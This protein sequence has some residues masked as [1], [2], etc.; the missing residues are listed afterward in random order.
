MS[1]IF[2]ATYSAGED[3]NYAAGDGR[4]SLVGGSV[5]AGKLD[6]TG[7]TVKYCDYPGK[8]NT[9]PSISSAF[10]FRVIP[11]YTGSPASNQIFFTLCNTNNSK[12]I[13]KLYHATNGKIH[14][15]M[16]G[17]TEN[18]L[19]DS[20]YAYTFSP[21]A[22]TTYEIEINI[23]IESPFIRIRLYVSGTQQDLLN[24]TSTDENLRGKADT[25]RIGSDK[26]PTVTS[27]F[28]I[29]HFAVYNIYQ[30]QGSPYTPAALSDTEPV[31]G[32][33]KHLFNC[34]FD[35]FRGLLYPE[36]LNEQHTVEAHNFGSVTRYGF[37]LYQV[38]DNIE[39]I[40]LG[41]DPF[42]ETIGEPAADEYRA[43]FYGGP[44]ASADTDTPHTFTG[45]SAFVEVNSAH[46]AQEFD[47]TYDGAGSPATVQNMLYRIREA[48]TIDSTEG[49]LRILGDLNIGVGL[50]NGNLTV[51]GRL[52]IAN[53]QY[54][55]YAFIHVLAGG[56][57]IE[58]GRHIN[59]H[60]E[61]FF[62]GR[63][64]I[65]ISAGNTFNTLTIDTS[66]APNFPSSVIYS[67][68]IAQIKT[69]DLYTDDALNVDEDEYRDNDLR[70]YID[71]FEDGSGPP[72]SITVKAEMDSALGGDI[73]V[74]FMFFGIGND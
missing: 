72:P 14:L 41:T 25:L 31:T 3:A 42:L 11:N 29:D 61:K 10:N 18:V 58:N 63:A 40:Y 38:P 68:V 13:I 12:N 67:I 71:V 47:V 37:F 17:K 55:V 53:G 39:S 15:Y 44:G 1:I 60:N 27:D 2:G 16:T 51:A 23:I 7:G 20:D 4:G 22:G 54:D 62:W 36:R 5:S 69:S 74:Q 26:I 45:S 28:R 65:G 56:G 43:D 66:N 48:G 57:D 52:E 9:P 21:V 19:K 46:N 59:Q 24:I 34:P 30:H 32:F 6:L 70:V 35:P 8:Y 33:E 64:E 50:S 49:L 73:A